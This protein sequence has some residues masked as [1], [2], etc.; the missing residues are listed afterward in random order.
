MA[1]GPAL[2]PDG[3]ASITCEQGGIRL[4]SASVTMALAA[5]PGAAATPT[6]PAAQ[7]SRTPLV[8]NDSTIDRAIACEGLQNE[9]RQA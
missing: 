8:V 3:T 4:E 5:A 2:A 9:I 1:V 7:G 6:A